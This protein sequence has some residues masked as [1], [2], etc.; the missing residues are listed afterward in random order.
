[1]NAYFLD[2]MIRLWFLLWGLFCAGCAA[3]WFSDEPDW[4]KSNA[5]LKFMAG[6]GVLIGSALALLAV[7][8]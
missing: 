1:M 2:V 6:V 3:L 4:V 8:Y 5:K 7:G